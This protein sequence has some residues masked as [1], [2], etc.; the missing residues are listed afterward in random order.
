MIGD[1]DSTKPILSDEQINFFLGETANIYLAAANAIEQG[2]LPAIARDVDR[3]G[4]GFSATRSQKTTHY[5]DLAAMLRAKSGS[6][7]YPVW[8]GTSVSDR[9]DYDDDTDW[10][11]PSF[12]TGMND[13]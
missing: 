12:A 8:G 13:K 3:Q 2:I 6:V 9:S 11:Q 1:T 5:R 4:T 7:A 10:V